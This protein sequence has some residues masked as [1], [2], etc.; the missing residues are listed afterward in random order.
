[1]R[2]QLC[3]RLHSA[4]IGPLGD[5]S[6]TH[7]RKKIYLFFIIFLQLPSLWESLKRCRAAASSKVPRSDRFATLQHLDC[8]GLGF[9]ER[10]RLLRGS[11]KSCGRSDGNGVLL[12]KQ[13]VFNYEKVACLS[14]AIKDCFNMF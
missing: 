10:W 3:K 9:D 7:T 13:W 5:G 6:F 1:M 8:E 4:P 12:F 14:F 2:H 11:G